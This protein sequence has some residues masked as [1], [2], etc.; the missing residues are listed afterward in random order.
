MTTLEFDA[1]GIPAPQGSKKLGRN[2]RTNRPI[3]INDNDVSL[4]RWR[5]S[6][7][8][9]ALIALRHAGVPRAEAGVPVLISI[10]FYFD[11]PLD[12][13]GTGRNLRILKRYRDINDRPGATI[14]VETMCRRCGCTD[15]HPCP[16]PCSWLEPGLC[17]S[18]A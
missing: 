3:L 18:C 13:Y 2:R 9:S 12:H 7:H 16:I 15:D 8:Q 17:S 14:L 1:P 6:V 11:R 4:K 10:V 5:A